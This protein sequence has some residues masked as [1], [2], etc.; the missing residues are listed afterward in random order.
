MKVEGRINPATQEQKRRIF[1]LC[2]RIGLNIEEA[3]ARGYLIREW[4]G[5]R[6]NGMSTLGF[7][8]AMNII[9]YLE[10][11]MRKGQR[12]KKEVYSAEMDKKRKG[13][14]KAV[15]RWLENQGKQPSMEYVKGIIC[16]AGGV[17]NINELSAEALTRL[18]AEFCRKQSA[19]Q[20]MQ[21]ES[22]MR[23]GEN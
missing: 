1:W 5:G 22:L 16:R 23:F 13:L 15:F 12:E 19:Q 3:S 11:M 18:Y 21:Q 8:D 9:K 6:S 17:H 7:I 20:E 10:E 2:S 14:I 4:T